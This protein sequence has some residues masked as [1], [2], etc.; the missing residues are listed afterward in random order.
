MKNNAQIRSKLVG[1]IL[2]LLDMPK[3]DQDALKHLQDRKNLYRSQSSMRLKT[4]KK[5]GFSKP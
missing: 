4:I 3:H 1:K 5:H 2:P